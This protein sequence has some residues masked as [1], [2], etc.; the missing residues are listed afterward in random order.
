MPFVSSGAELQVRNL[1]AAILINI[2]VIRLKSFQFRFFSP[3]SPRAQLVRSML[4][5][6]M[7]DLSMV[8]GEVVDRV[9]ALKFPALPD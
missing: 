7:L 5:W 9:V 1:K 8:N 3:E 2:R 6:R 4:L